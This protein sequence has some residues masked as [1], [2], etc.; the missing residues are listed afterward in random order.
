MRTNLLVT[1]VGG[2]TSSRN[3]SNFKYT[4]KY[5][6]F[7]ADIAVRSAFAREHA[8]SV[9]ANYD[10]YHFTGLKTS[11]TFV[12]NYSSGEPFAYTHG[13]YKDCGFWGL[14]TES[15]RD[16]TA[17]VYVP[18]IQ[19]HHIRWCGYGYSIYLL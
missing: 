13:N 18:Q 6:D 14:D 4:P 12:L 15:C 1:T 5:E 2:Q 11:Y 16:A 19:Q 8:T 17:A 10:A 7:N 9:V 3:I